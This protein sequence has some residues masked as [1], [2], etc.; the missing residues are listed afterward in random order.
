MKTSVCIAILSYLVDSEAL[1]VGNIKIVGQSGGIPQYLPGKYECYK[2]MNI[3]IMHYLSLNNILSQRC[4]NFINKISGSYVN[5]IPRWTLESSQNELNPDKITLSLKQLIGSGSLSPSQQDGGVSQ[6]QTVQQFVNPISNDELWWPL[7]I[8]TIQIRPS[9]D[10]FMNSASPSYLLAGLQVRVPPSSSKDG[11]EWK[12]FGMKSQPIASQWT[13]FGLA[14]ENGFRVE[15][16]IG[17]MQN[18][19]NEQDNEGIDW[20]PLYS[21]D[22]DEQSCY[23]QKNAAA[24]STSNAIEIFGG[25]LAELDENSPLASGMHILS[26][27]VDNHWRDLPS[28]NLEKNEQIRIASIGTVEPDAMELLSMDET[29]VE[30]SATSL[31]NINVLR[32][33]PGSESEYIPVSL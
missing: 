19:D 32:I 18:N 12:N 10:V 23:S 6:P 29:L 5:T 2:S 27:P 22:D 4:N 14:V 13:S 9:L 30:M 31:L 21:L 15:T 3:I 8:Q 26:I 33:A 28:P 17:K 24:S 16:F 11:Q 25:F 7:D 1:V 20:E